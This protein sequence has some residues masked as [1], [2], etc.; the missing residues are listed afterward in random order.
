MTEPDDPSS[1]KDL[2]SR[3]KAAQARR[4][5]EQDRLD[6]KDGRPATSGMGFGFR[7]AM[8]I[9]AALVVGGGGS[10]WFYQSRLAPKKE[11]RGAIDRAST[12]LAEVR[13]ETRSACS[14]LKLLIRESYMPEAK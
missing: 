9:L 1:L 7:I 5:A 3:L 12:R 2:D 10:Y 14:L 13:E 4:K 11:A 6:G 8:D